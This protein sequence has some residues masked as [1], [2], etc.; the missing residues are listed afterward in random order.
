MLGRRRFLV[1]GLAM[2]AVGGAA[3]C[4]P[5][6]AGIVTHADY[7][8]AYRPGLTAAERHDHDRVGHGSQ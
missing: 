2:V 8:I 7:G 3:T 5:A 1:L 6:R 4:P